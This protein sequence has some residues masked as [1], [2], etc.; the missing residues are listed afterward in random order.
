MSLNPL[1]M[2]VGVSGQGKSTAIRHLDPKKTIVLNTEDKPLPF[3]EKNLFEV[4]YTP[5][6][7]VLFE[8]LE[9]LKSRPEIETVVFDSF[10]SWVEDLEEEAEILT[11]GN[12]NKHEKWNVYRKRIRSFFKRVKKLG[13]KFIILGHPQVTENP[14]GDSLKSLA[15]SGQWKGRIEKEAIIVLYAVSLK[16]K[17]QMPEYNFQTQSDGTTTA[18]SP[19]GMFEDFLIPNNY[20][21]VVDAINEYYKEEFEAEKLEEIK[22]ETVAPTAL[23]TGLELVKLAKDT[24]ELTDIWNK[25]KELRVEP[26]F[27]QA[28]GKRNKELSTPKKTVE[29]LSDKE[30]EE[31]TGG[32]VIAKVPRTKKEREAQIAEM[33]KQSPEEII[34]RISDEI[35]NT[36]VTDNFLMELIYQD[37]L[38]VDEKK[39]LDEAQVHEL[40]KTLREKYAR[41][42]NGEKF[43]IEDPKWEEAK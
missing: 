35:E 3:R 21:L 25:Y 42:S 11:K 18:K 4:K 34:K 7:K 29:D 28:V 1:V 26:D 37:I 38:R 12:T 20:Q 19:L 5:S 10:T 39:E 8:H 15:V 13:K 30:V 32:K 6:T 24:K 22:K 36:D 17:N 23:E 43:P 40:K 16:E 9:A 14:D 27:K 41:F 2:V 33:F 31:I